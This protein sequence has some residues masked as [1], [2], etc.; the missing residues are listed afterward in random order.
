MLDL[1]PSEI[2][3]MIWQAYLDDTVQETPLYQNYC[4]NGRCK[5]F[6][7]LWERCIVPKA[8]DIRNRTFQ[9]GLC[10]LELFNDLR[11]IRAQLL[12]FA[13]DCEKMVAAKIGNPFGDLLL[14]NRQIRAEVSAALG[15]KGRVIPAVVYCS[16]RVQDLEER[17]SFVAP[18]IWDK[19]VLPKTLEEAGLSEWLPMRLADT[20][21]PLIPLMR[22]WKEPVGRQS[23]PLRSMLLPYR[24]TCGAGREA[25]A[26][27]V[28]V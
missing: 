19:D 1:L 24:Q 16:K 18:K 25:R 15:R 22:C 4:V 23:V 17:C 10:R 5:T 7:M 2:R 12:R 9:R 28:G 27:L 14:C 21:S 26:G 8:V 6:L 3:N 13:R 11:L 20:C